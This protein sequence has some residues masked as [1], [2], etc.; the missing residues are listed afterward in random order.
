MGSKNWDQIKKTVGTILV[1]LGKLSFGSLIFGSIL[2]GGFDPFH[3]FIVGTTLA[4][5]FF[6][7]GVLLLTKGKE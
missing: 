3:T 6:V 5:V 4:I 1:D 2:K 7:I